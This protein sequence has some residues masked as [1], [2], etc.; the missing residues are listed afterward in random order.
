MIAMAVG[1]ALALVALAYVLHPLLNESGE[2]GT[3]AKPP[4]CPKCG[5]QSEV[6]ARFCSSCGSEVERGVTKNRDG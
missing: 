2:Q 4:G 3:S 1:T 5:A 6:D